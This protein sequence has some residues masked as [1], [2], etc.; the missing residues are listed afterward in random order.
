MVG[1]VVFTKE[2]FMKP[3]RSGYAMPEEVWHRFIE[4]LQDHKEFSSIT[5]YISPER[6]ECNLPVQDRTVYKDT[7]NEEW[8]Y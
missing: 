1:T 7:S 2:E 8:F 6:I 5:Y 3:G 4:L